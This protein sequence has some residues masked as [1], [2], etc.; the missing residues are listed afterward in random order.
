M[1]EN[2]HAGAHFQQNRKLYKPATSLKDY[3]I[4]NTLGRIYILILVI[5]FKSY[6]RK[7][8]VNYIKI[9]LRI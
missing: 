8:C 2:I 6:K 5:S 4:P 7:L 3:E 1:P 9:K